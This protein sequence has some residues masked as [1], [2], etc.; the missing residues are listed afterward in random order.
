VRSAPV[1]ERARRVVAALKRLYPGVRCALAHRDP[2]E[3]YVATVLSAQ[4]SDERVNQVTPKLFARYPTPAALAGA[5]RAEIESL[6]RPTGF[7]RNKARSIQEG[8][9][10]IAE[11]FAGEV[12]HTLDELVTIPGTGRKT[13]NVI[14]GCAFGIPGITVDT[15]VRLLAGRLGWTASEDPVKIEFE[16]MEILPRRD[17]TAA[18]L[19]LIQHGRRVCTARKP[20]CPECAVLEW[21]PT[22][23]ELT[24][25]PGAATPR[26]AAARASA[27]PRRGRPRSSGTARR[28][29]GSAG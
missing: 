10:R 12:P 3:L 2:F 24:R 6:V 13:A 1:A 15:H 22:G 25:A 9:R 7:F 23:R 11:A 28:G 19:L 17:W 14:L 16:L 21:C 20:R 5:P 27:A 4:C 26:P 18:S 29:G 8:A